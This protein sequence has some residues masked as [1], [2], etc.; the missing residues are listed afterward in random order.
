LDHPREIVPLTLQQ[1]DSVV[2]LLRHI[3]MLVNREDENIGEV[4]GRIVRPD[5]C[6]VL[7][8]IVKNH[9]HKRGGWIYFL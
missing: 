7:L 6:N 3:I 1:P 2:Q 8:D 5:E 4:K 9:F